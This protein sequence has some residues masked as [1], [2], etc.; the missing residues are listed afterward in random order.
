MAAQPVDSNSPHPMLASI[1]DQLACP[2]CSSPLALN[3][4]SLTCTGCGSVYPVV[5]GIP[6]LIPNS[7]D[8]NDGLKPPGV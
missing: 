5:D 1:L 7:A 8:D 4:D 6:V 3:P 2:A